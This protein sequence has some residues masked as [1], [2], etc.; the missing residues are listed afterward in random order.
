VQNLETSIGCYTTQKEK[1]R[2]PPTLT[3]IV[4]VRFGQKVIY[5]SQNVTVE[6]KQYQLITVREHRRGDKKNPILGR[7]G[8]FSI[9]ELLQ[10]TL[11]KIVKI[12]K[13]NTTLL[14]SFNTR[15]YDSTN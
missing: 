9:L 14:I 1:S 10:Y 7:E 13:L 15:C 6:I 3:D 8:T 12:L 2:M 5:S 11:C 4:I